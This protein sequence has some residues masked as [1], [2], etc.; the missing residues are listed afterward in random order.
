MRSIYREFHSLPAAIRDHGSLEDFLTGKDSMSFLRQLVGA[1]RRLFNGAKVGRSVDT[2]ILGRRV[3]T[4]EIGGEYGFLVEWTVLENRILFDA[5]Q[6]LARDKEKNPLF[7]T[8][9]S[10]VYNHH[11]T[12]PQV[13]GFFGRMGTGRIRVSDI[14]VALEER[15]RDSIY[16]LLPYLCARGDELTDALLQGKHEYAAQRSRTSDHP[17]TSEE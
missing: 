14:D 4:E 7:Q 15:V 10:Q 13:T 2:H 8:S 17:P 12:R 16:G 5:F 9:S 6:I 1:A 11:L 3:I